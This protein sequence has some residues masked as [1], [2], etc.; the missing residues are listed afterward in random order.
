MPTY[1]VPGNA[2]TVT[3]IGAGITGLGAAHYFYHRNHHRVR[4]TVR[5]MSP[6]SRAV[7]TLALLCPSITVGCRTDEV[8]APSLK[9]TPTEV[10]WTGCF[11]GTTTV[12]WLAVQDGTGPW[13]QITSANKTFT[14][15]LDSNRAGVAYTTVGV[16]GV[17]YS[18]TTIRF[19]TAEELAHARPLCIGLFRVG[20]KD[21]RGTVAALGPLEHTEIALARSSATTN[22]SGGGGPA[23][24]FLANVESAPADLMAVR[25]VSCQNPS[26][27]AAATGMIIR[28]GVDPPSGTTLSILDFSDTREAFQLLS[29]T[30]TIQ[31]TAAGETMLVGEAFSTPRTPNGVE[32]MSSTELKAAAPTARVAYYAVPDDRLATGDVHRISVLAMSAVAG[33]EALVETHSADDLTI[34]LGSPF[35]PVTL[36]T[37]LQPGFATVSTEVAQTAGAKAWL[38]KYTQSGG[39]YINVRVSAGYARTG[40]V[41]LGV[42]SFAGVPG[43]SSSWGLRPGT[44]AYWNIAAI[45][46]EAALIESV[47]DVIPPYQASFRFGSVTP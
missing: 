39:L 35:P 29:R 4:P 19:Y 5:T 47:A 16:T 40:K 38:A 23:T 26:T 24:F 43:W 33:H 15:H 28:R 8:S 32:V 30:L 7:A 1:E 37:A 21:V 18:E 44:V 13:R 25:R 3:I 20:G 46:L 22:G 42:P 10:T 27:C 12:A 2:H 31:G 6:L 9:S 36:V 41:K 34:T 14:F 17:E 11:N 45:N